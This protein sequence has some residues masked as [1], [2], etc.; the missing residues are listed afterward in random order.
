VTINDKL[1][2]DY[3]LFYFQTFGYGK[4]GDFS[5]LY[6]CC[7]IVGGIYFF[8]CLEY[9]MKMY[10]RFKD[11]SGYSSGHGHSHCLSNVSKDTNLKKLNDVLVLRKNQLS[12]INSVLS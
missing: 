1:K 12:Q 10:V 4:N 11:G 7:V 5:Y 8:F 2:Q 3:F 6:K 9:L